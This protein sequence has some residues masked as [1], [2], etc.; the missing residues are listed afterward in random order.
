[1]VRTLCVGAAF[2]LLG[3]TPRVVV[4]DDGVPSKLKPLPVTITVKG[5]GAPDEMVRSIEGR[6][7]KTFATLGHEVT[8]SGV[9]V[10]IEHRPAVVKGTD[11]CVVLEG[12]AIRGERFAQQRDAQVMRC[13]DTK[14]KPFFSGTGARDIDALLLPIIV[15]AA[16]AMEVDQ[17]EGVSKVYVEAVDELVQTLSRR[18][19]A[20]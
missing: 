12:R 17:P 6:A 19:Q 20:E 4:K 8:I 16:L 7:R 14:E 2:L 15:A 1:M 18:A 3:C 9:V 10:E 13:M 5:N 11:W